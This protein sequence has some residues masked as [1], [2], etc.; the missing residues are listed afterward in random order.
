MSQAEELVEEVEEPK[1][2]SQD[3]VGGNRTAG[4]SFKSPGGSPS[5]GSPQLRH[6]LYCM[7][8]LRGIGASVRP[9]AS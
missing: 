9:G 6:L 1:A 7:R 5:G 8:S 3:G 2:S 4:R